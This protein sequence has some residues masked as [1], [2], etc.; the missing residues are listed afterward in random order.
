M[1]FFSEN[2]QDL[3]QLYITKLKSAYG[4]EKQITEALPKMQEAATDPQLKQAF[5]SHLQETEIHVQRLDQILNDLT[6]EV[7]GNKC[8]VTASL[9]DAG[10]SIAKDVKDESVR[11][12]ALIGA[13]QAVEHFE[14]ATYGTLRHW[15][16]LLGFPQHAELLNQTLQEEGHADKL[17]TSIADRETPG[18]SRAA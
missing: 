6:G 12:V 17:L 5:Q 4:S 10:D 1:K 13:A 14:M 9:I 2:I 8:K 18:V 7:D 3:K 15:A 16:K 11:D